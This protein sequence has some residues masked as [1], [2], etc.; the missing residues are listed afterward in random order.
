MSVEL[1]DQVQ[2]S[3]GTAYTIER[4][5]GGGGMSRTYVAMEQAL[6]RRVV[7]KV[8]SPEL[9]AGVSVDRFRREIMLAAKL[10]HPHV[11]PVLS[12][13][14][15]DGLPWF[16]MP[17]VE[18]ESLRARLS[19]GPMGLGEI[20]GILRDVAR[21]LEFAHGHGVVHRDIKPDNVLLAGSSA[22]VTDFGIAKA[23]SAARTGPE[24]ATLTMAGTSIG[25][26][27]YMAPEQAA[28]DPNIDHRSDIYAFGC[29]AYELLAGRPPFAG[30]SPAKLLGAHLG[31]TPRDIR[32]FRADT[33][34]TLADLVMRCLQKD[35]DARPSQAIH[36]VRVL[37]SVTSSG[38]S[39]A[40]PAILAPRIRAGRALALWA[41][42]TAL[43]ALTAWAATS[44]IGLPS[45]VFP[46]SLG[47]M[48]AGLPA[49]AFTAWVQRTTQKA[50]TATPTFTPG[51]TPTGQGTLLTLAM[52]ASPHVSWQRT[53]MGG[54]IAVGAF[55][56]LV[57]GFMV[58]RA[59]GIGPAGSLMARGAFGVKEKLIVAD[60]RGPANDST[61]GATVAEAIRTDLTQSA[62]LNV[63]TRAA[64]RDVMQLMQKDPGATMMYETA[65]EVATREGAKALLDGSVERVGTGYVVSARLVSALD[66]GEMATF[67]AT[68]ANDGELISSLGGLAKD[69]RER[70]GESLKSIRA[71]KSLERVTTSSLP[72]LKKYVEGL[73]SIQALGDIDRGRALLYESVAID[74]TFAMA[75]RR[76]AASYA[77]AGSGRAAQMAAIEKAYR[78]RDRL[79]DNER[80]VTEAGYHSYGPAPDL[81][82][83][84]A[85]YEALV[86]RDSLNGPALNNGG[87]RFSRKRDYARAEQWLRRASSLQGPFGGSFTNLADVQITQGKFAAAESTAAAFRAALPSNASHW[88]TDASIAIGRQDFDR[89]DEV[90]IATYNDP[91]AA[92]QRDF[93]SLLRMQTSSVRG[94]IRQALRFAGETESILAA[95]SDTKMPVLR[96]SLDSAW[97]RALFLGESVQAREQ[98][99]KALAAV[100]M[101][102]LPASERQWQFLIAIAQVSGDAAAA[103]AALRSFERDLPQMGVDQSAGT[104][105]E[106][107]G[108]VALAEGRAADAIPLFREADRTYASCHRCAMIDLARAFD[109]AG[110]RDSAILYFQQFVTTPTGD[111]FENQDW[112]A[113]SYKRLGE[114]YEAAGDLPRAVTNLEKFV[115]LW[116][117]ADPELQPKVREARERVTR[118][119]AELARRG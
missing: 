80:L 99:R 119:R 77:G 105:A 94:Q 104:L 1:R 79:S 36:L 11:V 3:L 44:V 21:A 101:E 93:T 88:V 59:M 56:V 63:M 39:A 115:E 45:W 51:G 53:W 29:M 15:A 37:D 85:A 76:I 9:A 12:S 26:P 52:K 69:I 23:I 96:A 67:R 78:H 17:Y 106:A 40:A 83:T 70:V 91:K 13:G 19:R 100:P 65:R 42:A 49:I 113:G 112:L 75:W 95:R 50:Y 89:L 7:V 58:M 108:Q 2:L 22:T 54:V 5:L 41:G 4:E 92:S 111:M 31:E 18:G 55:V 98:V 25:S 27:A 30:S 81:E 20:T 71:A 33:P 117:D 6:S 48:M 84:I 90:T 57:V 114:L 64:V 46:G 103:R 32:D 66:G 47:V 38:S 74:S 107:R 118:I 116:K 16:T 24:G 110:Q 60:F 14:D 109:L 62:N 8:L 10:Q 68:A 35:P 72:A 34:P 102:S 97:L 86:E 87:L 82:R 61:L 28:G 43:V 73:H